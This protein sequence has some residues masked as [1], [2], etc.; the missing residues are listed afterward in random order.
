ME[1][2]DFDVIEQED[3]DLADLIEGVKEE[4]EMLLEDF[5]DFNSDDF[6]SFGHRRFNSKMAEAIE[7]RFRRVA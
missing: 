2:F 1:Q 3:E 7:A 6:D 4:L 5:E